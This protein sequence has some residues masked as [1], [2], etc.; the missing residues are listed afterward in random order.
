MPENEKKVAQAY[1]FSDFEK[2]SADLCL[3]AIVSLKNMIKKL[4]AKSKILTNLKIIDLL[5]RI[6]ALDISF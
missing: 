4:S 5:T 2:D 1:I 6:K 3:I